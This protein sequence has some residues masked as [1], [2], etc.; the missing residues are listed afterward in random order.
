[1]PP[2]RAC[3]SAELHT[4]LDLG[5][6]PAADHFPPAATAVHPAESAHPLRMRLCAGCG[7]AQLAEDD[8]ITREPRGVEPRALRDQAADAVGRVAASGLLR[9]GSV[10]EFGSPHGG[11]WLPLLTRRGFATT[12]RAADVVID[13][14]GLMHHADQR[15]AVA[16]RAEATAPGGLLLVQY[17]SFATIVA[18]RQWNA[19]R[20]GHFAYYS[21]EAL[22]RLL[23]VAGMTVVTGW[24]FD[25]YG[26]TVLVAARHGAHE[27]DESIRAIRAAEAP[28][29]EPAAARELQCA[30]DMH[31]TALR[32]RLEYEKARGKRVYAYG[33]ASRAVAVFSRAGIHRGLIGAVA[34]AAPAKRGRRMPGTDIP[35]IGPAELLAAAPDLVLLTLPDL[36]EEVR[37]DFPGLHGRWLIDDAAGP[38]SET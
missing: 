13:C 17:H 16:A 31:A 4:V 34:D 32:E 28:F 36:L 27:P 5:K 19:L 24:T 29:T 26:G 21:L 11:S 18:A 1:M 22:Q 12:A 7:L 15:A 20:H 14:F 37:A 3:G 33:A 25:L 8:T 10:R 2:C 35:I 38:K 9:G 30:A 6:V 23:M